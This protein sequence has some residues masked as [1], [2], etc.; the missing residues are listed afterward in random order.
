[1]ALTYR[2][3][4]KYHH[5]RYFKSQLPP[6]LSKVLK[7]YLFHFTVIVM[8]TWFTIIGRVAQIEGISD[9]FYK[10]ALIEFQEGSPTDENTFSWRTFYITF[11]G[12]LMESGR[13]YLIFGT[14]RLTGNDESTPPK[15]RFLPY[16]WSFTIPS[17]QPFQTFW[18]LILSSHTAYLVY[19]NQCY[20]LNFGKA[21]RPLLEDSNS[22]RPENLPQA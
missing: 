4:Q 15:V 3:D 16:P 13:S 2:V 10:N 6:Q 11:W 14:G 22:R 9:S 5:L 19:S 12:D 17:N 20:S 8:A 21:T 7:F 1:L 18:N